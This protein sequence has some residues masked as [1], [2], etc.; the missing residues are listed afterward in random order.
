[1]QFFAKGVALH[2]AFWHRDFGHI[3]S[4]GCVNLAPIDAARLF[5]LTSPHLPSAWSASLPVGRRAGHHRAG[6]LG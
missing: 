2:A 6:A 1:M 5:K 4:H 3:H